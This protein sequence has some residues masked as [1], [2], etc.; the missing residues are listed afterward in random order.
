VKTFTDNS[1][2]LWNVEINVAA[3]KRVRDLAGV[4]LL[5]IVEGKLIERLIR[6][7]ILLCEIV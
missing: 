6:D 2:R 1:E 7:P 4:D 3:V 5:E